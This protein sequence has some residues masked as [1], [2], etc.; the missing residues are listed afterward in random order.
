MRNKILL[1]IGTL[2]IV[3]VLLWVAQNRTS[4]R[5]FHHNGEVFG[6]YYNISYQS[7]RGYEQEI[8]S[9]LSKVDSS[10]SIYTKGSTIYNINHNVSFTTD[11]LFEVMYTT[12]KEVYTLSNGAFDI[13]IAP[14]V[15][16]WGFGTGIKGTSLSSHQIDSLRMIVGMDKI[17][18]EDHQLIKSDT[19]ILLDAN[20]IAK[21]LGCDVVAHLLETKGCENYLVDIGGEV[22]V[23]GCNSQGKLWQ[24]GIA[25]PQDDTTGTVQDVQEV[26]Q[27]PY[28]C[29]ATSGNYRQYY[30]RD[31]LRCSHTIDPR[32]GYPVQHN[33]LSA[34]IRSHSC[35]RSDA[36][37][38][39]C[40]VLGVDTSLELLERDTT[41]AG[42]L[43]Y[44][45]STGYKIVH[46]NN[47]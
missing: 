32:T 44:D 35:M 18:L 2:I 6:T 24:V 9:E 45:T 27:I 36:V 38:T 37:A 15:N 4:Q 23:R 25:S 19:R 5:Y 12:A 10:L 21:G 28:G 31:T 43:I 13:T 7:P 46:T 39:A 8:L 20:A 22:V 29:V 40:M 26:L 33:L 16:A 34:T 41:L 11:S 14:L 42:Y 1:P 30:Y 3:C 47:W 17:R